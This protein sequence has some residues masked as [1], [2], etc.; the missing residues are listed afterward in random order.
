MKNVYTI[1]NNGKYLTTYTTNKNLYTAAL[2][3][4]KLYNK[5]FKFDKKEAKREWVNHNIIRC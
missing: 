1:T 4:V 2:D 5:T 3:I